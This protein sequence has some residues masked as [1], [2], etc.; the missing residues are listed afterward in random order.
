MRMERKGGWQAEAVAAVRVEVTRWKKD[1]TVAWAT[2]V[3]RA[4]VREAAKR[5]ACA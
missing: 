5:R 3:G 2:M 4:V 1:A